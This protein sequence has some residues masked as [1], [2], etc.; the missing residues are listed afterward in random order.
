M[1]IA[2]AYPA[3][4]AAACRERRKQKYSTLQG[5]VEELS[6]R[7]GQLSTLEA[8]NSE[9]QQRNTQLEVVVKEQNAQLQMQK[10]T[11]T[12]QAQQLHTQVGCCWPYGMGGFNW[13]ALLA[14]ECSGLMVRCV[15][16]ATLPA[17]QERA[18]LGCWLHT[19]Q[20]CSRSCVLVIEP[21]CLWP[22]LPCFIV[23]A[24]LGVAAGRRADTAVMN[25]CCCRPCSWGARPS[26]F[27][28]RS[29]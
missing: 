27:R 10:D 8:A 7:L 14:A 3:A 5:T 23:V 11:I 6:N 9:L 2:T 20:S 29:V 12:R 22:A 19:P 26:S 21:L 25:C 18:E 17:N 16:S 24:K 28:L 1:L 4:I 13:C 15:L